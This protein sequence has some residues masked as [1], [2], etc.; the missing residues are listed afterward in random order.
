[1]ILGRRGTGA[2][3]EFLRQSE[4][5]EGEGENRCQ[6]LGGTE[7]CILFGRGRGVMV[8]NKHPELG[9]KPDTH[10]SEGNMKSIGHDMLKRVISQGWRITITCY[11]HRPPT[12]KKE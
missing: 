9:I 11:I 4:V 7:I 6:S 5:K 1:M 2:T 10:T 8:W 12:P 3:E